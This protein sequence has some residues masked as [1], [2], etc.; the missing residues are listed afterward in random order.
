MP[1]VRKLGTQNED[2]YPVMVKTTQKD[3]LSKSVKLSAFLYSKKGKYKVS[4]DDIGRNIGVSAK[5]AANYFNHTEK[6]TMAIMKRICKAFEITADEIA[7][8]F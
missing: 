6:I 8:F 5:S 2:E 3:E 4:F 7:A 1:R